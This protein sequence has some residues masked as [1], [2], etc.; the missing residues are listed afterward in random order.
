ML[1]VADVYQICE[2]IGE[3]HNTNAGHTLHRHEDGFTENDNYPITM[4]CSGYNLSSTNPPGSAKVPRV[5]LVSAGVA[6]TDP[7]E[8]FGC[9]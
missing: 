6:H 8:S 7:Y 4:A 1:W 2:F 3:L 5:I 9:L